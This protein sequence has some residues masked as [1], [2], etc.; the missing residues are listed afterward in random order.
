MYSVVKKVQRPSRALPATRRKYPFPDMALGDMF[1]VAGAHD[2][3]Q[4][5]TTYVGEVQRKMAPKKFSV[6]RC[7]MRKVKGVWQL[8][9]PGERGAAEGLGV[10]RT[11]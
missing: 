6:R 4:S 11:K 7:W 3:Q 1:F 10:W 5:F 2:R 9:E 8:A